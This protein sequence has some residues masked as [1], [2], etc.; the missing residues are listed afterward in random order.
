MTITFHDV[1]LFIGAMLILVISPGPI[2]A[3]IIARVLSRGF[4]A[5][6]PIVCAVMVGDFLWVA[7]VAFGLAELVSQQIEIMWFIRYAGA[8]YLI[9][10]GWQEFRNASAPIEAAEIGGRKQFWPV[11][12]SGFVLIMTNPKAIIFYLAFVPN[13][14]EV[15]KLTPLDIVFIALVAAST[16][17]LGNMIWGAFASSAK[18]IISSESGRKTLR[19]VS[20]IMLIIVA[21][22][23]VVIK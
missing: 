5:M 3:A 11:F 7:I 8:A 1:W 20:G 21:I 14:F 6:W 2:V 9:Y 19:Q 15:S 10:L 4:H 17:F 13:F 22:V 16:A 12:F 23:L 18:A